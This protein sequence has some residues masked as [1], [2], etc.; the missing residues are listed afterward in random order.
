[1]LSEGGKLSQGADIVSLSCQ[2]DLR[3][4]AVR[5]TA[6]RNGLDYVEVTDGP[7][8]RLYVY[9]LGKLPG[10]LAAKTPQLAKYLRLSGGDRITG[11]KI[12]DV[13][14]QAGIDAEHDDFLVVTVD[15]VGDFSTYT[16]TLVGVKG[17]DPLYAS[18]TFTFRMDC[19]SDLDCKAPCGCPPTLTD[20]PTINYLAKDYASFRQLILDRMALLVPDWTER[21]VPDLGV[22]LVELLAYVGDYLSYYQDAVATEAYLGTARQRISVRRHARLVDYYLHEGCNARAWVQVGVSETLSLL[23]TQ[24]AFATGAN[25]ALGALPSVLSI[26]QLQRIPA[27]GYEYYEPLV[28]DASRPFEFR[29]AHNQIS[30][31]TWGRR[32]CCLVSGARQ[33]T[34]LDQWV[35]SPAP[36]PVPVPTPTPVPTPAP[37][38]TP[39]PTPI[40]QPSSPTTAASASA[41]NPPPPRALNI[42]VD[43]VLIFEEVLG[44]KTGTAVDA[45]PTRRW[46][47]RVTEAKLIEDSLFLVQVGEGDSALSRPTPLVEIRWAAE[48]ALP[49]AFCISALGPPPDCVYLDNISVVRGNIVPVDHGR[50]LPP[51]TLPPVPGI[52]TQSCCDCEGYPAD[53]VTETGWYRPTLSATPLTYCEISDASILPASTALT[54]D[55]RLAVPKMVLSDGAADWTICQDLL[56]SAADDRDFVVEI[57]NDAIA[58]LRFGDGNLG[59]SPDPGSAFSATYRIGCGLAGNVGSE[60]ISHLVLRNLKLDGVSITVRNPLPA[61]GGIDPETIAEAK[62]FAPHDFH[63]PAKIERAITAA[64]YATLAERNVTLQGAA[65]RLVWTGSWYEADV[66]VDPVRVETPGA[67][68]LEAVEGYLHPYRRIGHDLRV[69]A[70]V[71]VPIALSI[72]ACA[73]PGYDRGHVKAALAARFSNRVNL[74]GSVGFFYPDNLVFGADIYLSRIIAAAQAVPGVQCV[75]IERFHRLF[76]LPNQEI[77]NGVLPLAA[78]ELAQLDNDP[79]FP[80][81]GQLQ[82]VIGGGR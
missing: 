35:T 80:E 58:H 57:D 70:A 7:P 47:V 27:N 24:I 11:L 69:Q 74:D 13:T 52:T 30:I 31:Y 49:F 55:P 37:V 53:V 73:L 82:I 2:T 25:G 17:I 36:T 44:P 3:R 14:P 77:A 34:L 20:E 45:D 23:P 50:T 12:T 65:A 81:R 61:Q 46:A 38:P 59:R 71:Y 75:T 63:D 51:E 26:D 18:A 9:F 22:T 10:E 79:D 4:E 67:A 29:Q 6:G 48:D 21:H 43:D 62:L 16:L 39:P 66:S 32:E 68:L 56:E 8:V 54:Q 33:A 64:D 72:S 5:D 42:Q 19:P 76:A 78:N 15:Q 1:V 28:P 41:P 60:S 40:G